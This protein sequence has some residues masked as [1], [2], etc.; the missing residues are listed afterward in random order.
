M[1]LAPPPDCTGSIHLSPGVL[2]D[3]TDSVWDRFARSWDD[4]RADAHMADG[5]TY[6]QRRYGA[7]RLSGER[8]S[9]L[10][11]RAHFQ[12][13]SHNPLNGGS[14]RWF[15]PM[16]PEVAS[17]APFQGIVTAMAAQ[18]DP[19]PAWDIEAHQFRIC[20]N[21]AQPGL[22]TPEGMHRDGRDHVLIVLAGSSNITGGTTSIVDEQGRVLGD[23]RLTRP[24]EAL[25]LDDHRVRHGT[26]PIQPVSPLL[27]AWR[28][29]LVVTFAR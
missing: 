17:S 13:R 27:P 29:T 15:A 7:F 24:G 3:V 11:H 28:D 12:E 6:R 10:P 16:L 21:T 18:L 2:T 14:A 25:L 1:T 19:C 26:S 8:L 23:Y 22:P 5:G 9:R 4:L 20:A